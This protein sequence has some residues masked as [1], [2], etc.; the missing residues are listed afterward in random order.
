VGSCYSSGVSI[1]L[2][3]PNKIYGRICIHLSSS[4]ETLLS[5]GILSLPK[6]E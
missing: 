2:E 4:K 6:L 5:Q 3:W 1:R